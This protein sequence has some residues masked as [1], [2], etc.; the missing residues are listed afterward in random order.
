MNICKIISICNQK[1]GVGKTTTAVSLGV[2]LARTGKKV[3]LCDLDPQ[4]SATIS[5]GYHQPDE[6]PITMYNVMSQ[7][8]ERKLTLKPEE[9]ILT[10]EDLDFIPSNTQ[11]SLVE[12]SLINTMN[13]ENKLKMFLNTLKDKYDFIIIDCPPSLGMLTINALVASDSVVIPV[14]ASFLATKGLEALLESISNV[15]MEINPDLE[16]DGILITMFDKRTNFSKDVAE[17]ISKSYGEYIKVYKNYIPM[18][19]KAGETSTTGK[20]IFTYDKTSKIAESY[21]GLAKEVL[22][23]GKE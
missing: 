13:R 17:F 21:E 18:S 7:M 3:L 10:K 14:Q 4:G 23:Y 15:K 11:L 16:I 22:G 20:S 19:V 2:G 8:I 12:F 6:L 9:Y 1:G 5:L